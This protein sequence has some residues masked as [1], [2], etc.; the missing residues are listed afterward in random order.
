MSE[1]QDVANALQATHILWTSLSSLMAQKVETLM[2]TDIVDMTVI[3]QI[4]EG[5]TLLRSPSLKQRTFMCSRRMRCS[6]V[7]HLTCTVCQCVD[8]ISSRRLSSQAVVD[9]LAAAA[10]T[11]GAQL[12]LESIRIPYGWKPNQFLAANHCGVL[13]FSAVTDK[14]NSI[15]C[16]CNVSLG[17]NA[18]LLK[19][20]LFARFSGPCTYCLQSRTRC[21]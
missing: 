11:A 7:I 16:V 18:K 13:H 19:T 6:N 8:E 14:S 20:R 17:S 9:A 5:S 12:S 4:E 1:C 10:A 21:S 15:W 3:G 2:T